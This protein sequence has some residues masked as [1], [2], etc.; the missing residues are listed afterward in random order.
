MHLRRCASVAGWLWESVREFLKPPILGPICACGF[1]ELC[2]MGYDI[3]LVL[4]IDGAIGVALL[5]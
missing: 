1:L 4:Y 5:H 2:P 3:G